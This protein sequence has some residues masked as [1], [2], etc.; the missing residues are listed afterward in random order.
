MDW[1]QYVIFLEWDAADAP[2]LAQVPWTRVA[3][4]VTPAF[5]D[6]IRGIPTLDALIRQYSSYDRLESSFRT[7]ISSLGIPP[8]GSVYETQIRRIAQT[9]VRIGLTPDWYLGAYRLIWTTAQAAIPTDTVER[10]AIFAAVSKRLMA[11]IVLTITIYQSLLDERSASL[12]QVTRTMTSVQTDLDAQALQLANTAEQTQTAV[13]QMVDT[14]T[15]IATKSQVL[16]QTVT[17]AAVQAT[18]GVGAMTVLHDKTRIVDG[19]LEGVASAGQALTAQ[20]QAIGQATTLIRG[21]AQQTNLLALNAAIE[22]ARAGEA[23]RGFAVV[24]DEVKKLSQE[25]QKATA[26]IDETV[27]GIKDHLQQLQQVVTQAL[28]AQRA[29][30]DQSTTVT[31]ALTGIQQQVT[32]TVAEFEQLDTHV[33]S[34]MTGMQQLRE[35]ATLTHEQADAVARLAKQLQGS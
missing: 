1:N 27:T 2:Q 31:H 30:S 15:Q 21:I 20:T 29:S 35:T 8:V 11:D 24:A 34:A 22:A 16:T 32:A 18:D 5:Y 6:K 26:T 3:D 33:H 9:H 7:Y 25:S 19:V 17:Q 28:D 12:E 4:T 13:S 14:L 10:T 23:G